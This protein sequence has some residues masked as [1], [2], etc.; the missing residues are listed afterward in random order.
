MTT[1]FRSLFRCDKNK[2]NMEEWL[3]AQKIK[4]EK[5]PQS[6]PGT[7]ELI[8]INIHQWYATN[9][10]RP[11]YCNVCRDALYGKFIFSSITIKYLVVNYLKMPVHIKYYIYNTILLCR[12]YFPW[13]KL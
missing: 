4:M 11:M 13:F 6:D 3:N 7:A 2:Q 10:A 5:D 9:H 1:P 8:G 12:C